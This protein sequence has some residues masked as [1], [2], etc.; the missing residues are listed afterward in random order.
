[1]SDPMLKL[2]ILVRAELALADIHGRRAATRTA[3]FAV[4][5]VFLLLGLAMLTAA[6]YF[7]LAPI[8]GPALAAFTVAMVDTVI[9]IVI[10]L[11]ARNAGPSANEEKLALEI[12]NMAYSE[13]NND[14]E[15]VKSQFNEVAAEVKRIRS[16]I[17]SFTS[18]AAGTFGPLLSLLVKTV[19]RG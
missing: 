8:M 5:M 16:G 4:A 15:Q 12:R 10:A 19:K 9:G 3:Y 18:G 14:I 1:M 17:S 7:A 2:Q 13:L 11:G 6:V